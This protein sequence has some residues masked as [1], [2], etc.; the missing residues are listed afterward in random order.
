MDLETYASLIKDCVSILPEH[1]VLHRMTGDGPR[2]LLIAPLWCL[3]KKH[4]LNT[5]RR[6]LSE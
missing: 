1:T 2:R 4:V 3:E 6:K 5:L